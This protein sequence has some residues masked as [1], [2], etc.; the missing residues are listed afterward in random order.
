MEQKR[1]ADGSIIFIPIIGH[2]SKQPLQQPM[3]N[4]IVQTK[5]LQQIGNPV[6]IVSVTPKDNTLG[7]N[8]VYK[9]QQQ[10]PIIT[11][12]IQVVLYIY[13]YRCFTTTSTTYHR[14]C[15]QTPHFSQC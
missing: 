1:K 4:N 6:K 3:Y 11:H 10:A 9:Q 8:V 14:L 12:I 13:I 5:Q 7:T 15:Y 2:Q